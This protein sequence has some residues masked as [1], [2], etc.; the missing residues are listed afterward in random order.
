MDR[1]P[2]S[3]PE[4]ATR[5]AGAAADRILGRLPASAEAGLRRIY[6]RLLPLG[7]LRV[8]LARLHGVA[9]GSG[10]EASMLVAGPPHWTR[11]L[12]GRFFADTPRRDAIGH[13]T[14]WQLPRALRRLRTTADVTV[15]RVDRLSARLLFDDDWLRIPDWVG[16]RLPLPV[17]VAALARTSKSVAEDLRKS[18]RGGWTVEVSRAQ[19]DFG[20]FY[21]RMFVPYTLARHGAE[22]Y[23]KGF[24]HLQRSFRH[25]GILWLRRDGQPVAGELFERVGDTLVLQA[26]GVAGGEMALRQQG[27]VAALYVHIIE[28]AQRTG[29]TAIDMRGSRPSLAD[30]LLRYKAK[31]G[32]VLYD[33]N[34]DP[35]LSLL[36]WNRLDG[37]VAG[38]L[39]Q[40]PLL[41]RDGEGLSGV[42]FVD[43]SQPWTTADLQQACARLW[44]PG[45]A[46]LGI[47][48]GA[49][50]AD[51]LRAPAGVRLIAQDGVRA[52]GPRALLA[53]LGAA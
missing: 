49:A 41:I 7:A 29:C 47:V 42:G 30:G 21:E 17:D 20:P 39:A 4:P 45:L 33:R 23:V 19:A 12:P 37:A 40:T 36:Q 25:G 52:A 26:I 14:I 2:V 35:H 22:A 53:Q 32:T 44:V 15:A 5:A 8:P 6:A 1:P 48:A 24:H 9:R 13:V 38:F 28:H 46:R 34:D 50:R 11:Y 18:R 31:W 51:D 43:R 16:A 10:R 27:A 3:S